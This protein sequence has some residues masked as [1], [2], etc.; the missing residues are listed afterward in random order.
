MNKKELFEL[1]NKTPTPFYFYDLK[2]I[3]ERVNEIKKFFPNFN[4]LYSVK[5]NPH[6]TIIKL[7]RDLEVGF[8]VA[9]INELR[10]A[11]LDSV[12][13]DKIYYSSP[14]KKIEDLEYAVGK[15]HIIADSINE[16]SY[17]NSIANSLGHVQKV[18]IRLN[19]S[20]KVILQSKHEIMSGTSSK[21]G[22]SIEELECIDKLSLSNIEIVGI[23]IYFGSQ[24][25]DA[26]IIYNN[27]HLI[28]D[29]ALYLSNI[30]NIEYV[31]FGV[32]FG[33]P[34]EKDD[35][36][37]DLNTLAEYINMDCSI[38]KLIY[39]SINLNI[40]LGRY[41]VAECGYFV[42]S[43]LDVKTSL[44]RKFII[45]DGGMNNFYRPIM[46]GDYH[47]IIQINKKGKKE[48]VT[49]VGR[50]CTPI[51]KYYEDILIHCPTIGDKIVF[52]NAGAYGYTMS[53][54]DFIS[55]DKPYEIIING[56]IL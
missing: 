42:S 41:I 14:G 16:L 30:F 29:T 2:I 33:I 32:G 4:L 25:L 19:I 22:V 46:T 26:N 11:A 6:P 48:L 49:L 31:D 50:L 17:I 18:G 8:D 34:Y 38:Q 36:R 23:H 12:N 5:A 24:I 7:L 1:V 52:K 3:K 54:L 56:D 47:D 40:E 45:I 53:I 51:D 21:F 55:Y 27:F 15:C 20:N 9:S 44:N 13:I 43:V 10:L 37:I 39:S 35:I 28:A